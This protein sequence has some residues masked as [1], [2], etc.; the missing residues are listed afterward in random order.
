MQS[1]LQL[2]KKNPPTTFNGHVEFLCKT[3]KMCLSQKF[4]NA[5]ILETVRD[6]VISANSIQSHHLYQK[7]TPMPFLG[8]S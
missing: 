3:P 4:K 5:C 8:S 2:L 7:I 6:K 1:H